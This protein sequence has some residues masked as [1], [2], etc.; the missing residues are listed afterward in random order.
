MSKELKV[1]GKIMM[2]GVVMGEVTGVLIKD[3]QLDR[4]GEIMDISGISNLPPEDQPI[5][6]TVSCVRFESGWLEKLDGL[7][8]N[9][10][11]E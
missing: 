1:K 8:K 9:D 3:G 5:E 4:N 2:N 7:I 10:K 6:V 11:K